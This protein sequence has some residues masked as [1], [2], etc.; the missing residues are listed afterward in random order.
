[1][2]FHYIELQA[3]LI[4]FMIVLKDSTGI[5]KETT[6]KIYEVRNCKSF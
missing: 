1:M 3:V 2:C 6:K 5:G 4:M